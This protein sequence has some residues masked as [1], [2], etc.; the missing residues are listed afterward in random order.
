M[1][2]VPDSLQQA[3]AAVLGQ[4]I[5]AHGPEALD[6]LRMGFMAAMGFETPPAR[7]P[8]QDAPLI[9][10]GLEAKPF[11]TRDLYPEDCAMLEAAFGALR[12]EALAADESNRMTPW[13]EQHLVG[14]GAWDTLIL[15]RGN[16]TPNR[17]RCP[18]ATAVVES[19]PNM[20]FEGMFSVL[21]AGTRLK[22]HAGNWNCR[23]TIQMPL[24]VPKGCSL[25]AGGEVHE[26]EEGVPIV[27]DDSFEHDAWNDGDSTR[28]IVLLDVWHPQL[29]E[30]E[31]SVLGAISREFY[32]AVAD[33]AD[34]TSIVGAKG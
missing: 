1:L 26:L 30:V 31:R 27:F 6:R 13:A 25:R 10:P 16:D 15:K 12:E 8:K 3:A 11:H 21:R 28:I 24:V 9:F 19:L 33:G 23:L 34:P 32:A 7:A 29:T 5:E 22:P 4:A 17:A 20:G 18:R 14:S 2:Q